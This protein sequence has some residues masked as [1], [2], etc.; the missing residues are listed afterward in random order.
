M[1]GAP[2]IELHGDKFPVRAQVFLFNEF[3][4]HADQKELVA[5][6]QHMSGLS[7]IALVH[8]E[9]KESE[10]LAGALQAANAAWK[11]VRPEEGDIIA[12]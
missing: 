12:I 11:I 1:E 4:A 7:T 6:A 2:N 8:G 3:S 10:S 9:P 5:Y